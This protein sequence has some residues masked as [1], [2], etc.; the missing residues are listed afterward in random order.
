MVIKNEQKYI[1]GQNKDDN[2]LKNKAHIL[3]N[4]RLPFILESKMIL[5]IS[6]LSLTIS[7]ELKLFEISYEIM[8]FV[9]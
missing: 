2:I 7:I 4:Q 3:L 1:Y 9:A 6:Y 8:I 5:S